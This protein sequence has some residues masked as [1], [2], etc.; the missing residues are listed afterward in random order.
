[1]ARARYAPQQ[2]VVATGAGTPAVLTISPAAPFRIY[3]Q[4]IGGSP[5]TDLL[6][7]DGS[8]ALPVNGSG[9]PY[10]DLN[11]V[12]PVFYGP[13][14][15]TGVL[16]LDAFSGVRIPWFSASQLNAL[17]TVGAYVNN[18]TQTFQGPTH[19]SS[20]TASQFTTAPTVSG[21]TVAHA[22]NLAALFAADATLIAWHN[23]TGQPYFIYVNPSTGVWPNSGAF[24]TPSGGSLA[25]LTAP[26]IWSSVTWAG[27]LKPT[28]MLD[29]HVWW[30]RVS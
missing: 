18:V 17:M 20:A 12:P 26:V 8:T 24:V 28:G 3:P 16:W 9:Y 7:A 15:V 10:C 23:A 30:E 5:Y 4:E 13:D 22:G 14:G 2:L 21:S 27:A 29:N 19:F 11:G 25:S 6:A 1:V